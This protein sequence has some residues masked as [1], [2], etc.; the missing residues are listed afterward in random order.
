[1]MFVLSFLDSYLVARPRLV[2]EETTLI[3]EDP[4]LMLI[5]STN[6]L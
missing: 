4:I 5:L 3:S 2:T 1:M 6:V